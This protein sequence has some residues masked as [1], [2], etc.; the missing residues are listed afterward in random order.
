MINI[1]IPYVNFTQL[2]NL[3]CVCVRVFLLYPETENSDCLQFLK[4]GNNFCLFGGRHALCWNEGIFHA[5]RD[6]VFFHKLDETCIFPLAASAFCVNKD[7]LR[8]L[9]KRNE[10]DAS[11]LVLS[12][13]LPRNHWHRLKFV[14]WCR[15]KLTHDS[16]KPTVCQELCFI[17]T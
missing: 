17:F 2:S 10:E 8:L 12:Q 16:W 5:E 15:E 14:E 9:G 1:D 3:L 7:V 11:F 13:A 6:Y 4:W